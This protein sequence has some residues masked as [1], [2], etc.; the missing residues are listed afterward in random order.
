VDTAVALHESSI[1]IDGLTFYYDGASPRLRP[2][3]VTATNVTAAETAYGFA[4][5][6]AEIDEVRRAAVR[7]PGATLVLTASDIEAAKRGGKVGIIIGL[8]ASLPVDEDLGRV[9]ILYDLGVRIMQ[10]TY[11]D[12]TYAGDGCLEPIDGGLSQF[13][14][15]MIAEMAEVRMLLDLSHVGRHTCLE[16]IDACPVPM[17]I[18]HA[19]PVALTESPRNLSDE[20]IRAV[21]SRGGVIGA[22]AYPPI[23]WKNR[24]GVLPTAD[25]VLD[26]LDYMVELAGIDHVGI[27]TDSACTADAAR[28]AR[29]SKE[30]AG[31]FPEIT[32]DYNREVKSRVETPAPVPNVSDLLPITQ[33]LL[34]RGY[35]PDD[36]RK[37]LGGNFLRVFRDV[38]GA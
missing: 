33:G 32:E 27:A 2:D 34:R 17:V 15:A 19:N 35:A 16:A 21:A 5:A 14:R 10:L 26:H 8:Q 13:G 1:V 24:S 9:R 7:D 31:V 11:N 25:D 29:H 3:R 36:V 4:D 37:V 23:C 30:F 12:R 6:V 28:V 20:Q 18:S 22:C 38:W